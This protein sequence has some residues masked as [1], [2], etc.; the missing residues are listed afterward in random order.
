MCVGRKRQKSLRHVQ[1][2]V[3][4]QTVAPRLLRP[5][6]FPGMNAGVGCSFLLQGIFRTQG[7]NPCLPQC[8]HILQCLSP[9]GSP[10]IPAWGAIPCSGGLPDWVLSQRPMATM[11]LQTQASTPRSSLSVSVDVG[12]PLARLC[13]TTKGSHGGPGIKNLPA[14]AGDTGSVPGPGRSHMPRGN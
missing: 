8:R 1:L 2:F 9:Q 4:P 5:W 7:S 3:T 6:D 11:W 14:S 13:Y 10:R 12:S